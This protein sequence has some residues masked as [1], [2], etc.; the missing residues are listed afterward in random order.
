MD[1]HLRKTRHREKECISL[2]LEIRDSGGVIGEIGGN[3]DEGGKCCPR[4][5]KI[6]D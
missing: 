2:K 4:R 6:S 1:E 5:F 3:R